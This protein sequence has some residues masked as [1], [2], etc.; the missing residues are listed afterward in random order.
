MAKIKTKNEGQPLKLFNLR[1]AD[2]MIKNLSTVADKNGVSASFLVRKL[3][4]KFLD[5]EIDFMISSKD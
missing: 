1:M 5:N 3:I 4:E 2:S